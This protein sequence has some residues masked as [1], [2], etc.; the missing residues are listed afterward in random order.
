MG[1]SP[2]NLPILISQLPYV[3]KIAHTELSKSEVQKVL[4]GPI[5]NQQIRDNEAKIQQVDKKEKTD[6]V[7]RD[8]HQ[9]QQA[10]ADTRE[11]E[12]TKDEDED[13]DAGS[14][15]PSPWSGN[16]VNVKI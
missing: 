3:A 14:S 6:T 15:N 8:G 12:K 2:L 11:R 10:Q 7:D 1:A 5:I 4:F 16:I 13:P 9:Q